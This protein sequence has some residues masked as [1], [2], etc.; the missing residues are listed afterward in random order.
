MF[1]LSCLSLYLKSPGLDKT[2]AWLKS[3][4]RDSPLNTMNT[5]YLSLLCHPPPSPE[6]TSLDQGR[7]SEVSHTFH[8]LLLSSVLQHKLSSLH[9]DFNE[10]PFLQSLHSTLL[11]LAAPAAQQ[12]TET[13][14]GVSQRDTAKN[15]TAKNKTAKDETG[16][17]SEEQQQRIV[18]KA[19]EVCCGKV[20]G[21]EEALLRRVI[22]D[23]LQSI[24]ASSQMTSQDAVVKLLHSRLTGY[25]TQASLNR[26][27]TVP[28][29]FQLVA[30]DV[31]KC[32]RSFAKLVDFNRRVYG[33]FYARILQEIGS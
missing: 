16:M 19:V 17:F 29:G 11:I 3:N 7:F 25:L 6:T 32:A 28:K 4:S 5:A 2:K 15:K 30:A 31:E 21:M 24:L 1:N 8:I 26:K 27:V 22:N 9:P 14:T 13:D 23:S 10:H 20:P 33:P 12:E 18:I